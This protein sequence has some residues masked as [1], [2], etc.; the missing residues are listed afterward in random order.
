[1]LTQIQ[2]SVVSNSA[3]IDTINELLNEQVEPGLQTLTTEL[4]EIQDNFVAIAQ[5]V[6]TLQ[7]EVSDAGSVIVDLESKLAPVDNGDNDI[8]T[9]KSAAAL[10]MT[11]GTEDNTLSASFLRLNSVNSYSEVRSS[12]ITLATTSQAPAA[13]IVTISNEE[14]LMNHPNEVGVASQL[15]A[16][17]LRME[18]NSTFSDLTSSNIVFG[19]ADGGDEEIQVSASELLVTGGRTVRITNDA[20]VMVQPNV[21]EKQMAL[22]RDALQFVDGTAE[23][24]LSA[25]SLVLNEAGGTTSN[26]G[27]GQLRLV[28]GKNSVIITAPDDGSTAPWGVDDILDYEG[29]PLLWGPT[30]RW[31]A[32]TI[33]GTQYKMPALRVSKP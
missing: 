11:D 14:M 32:I 16:V 12:T 21:A 26:L 8:L 33:N 27:A 17:S 31:V 19:T 20:M 2:K 9:F 18:R 3:N 4:E 22:E 29:L 30:I 5:S 6:V 24:V 7:S 1:M 28:S 25:T 23:S 13:R 10:S 15:T